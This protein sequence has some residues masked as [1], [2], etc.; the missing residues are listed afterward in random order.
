MHPADE[1]EPDISVVVVNHNTAH[2]LDRMFAALQVARGTLQIEVLIVDN[3]S[4][5]DSVTLIRRKYPTAILIENSINV[6]FGRANNQ[7]V[8]LARGRYILLLNTD[9]FVSPDTLSKS[10]TFM[11]SHPDCGVLGVKLVS[12]DGT[13][14]PSCRNFP[15]PWNTFL[16]ATGFD[17]VFLRFASKDHRSEEHSAARAC[18]W[19]PGCYYLTRRSVVDQIGLFDPRYF[20]YFEEVDHCRR[21]HQAGWKVIY[22]PDTQVIHLGGE[23]AKSRGPIT[24]VSRQALELQVESELLYLRKHH[25]M[26]GVLAGILLETVSDLF[27][28]VKGVLGSR[29]RA[30]TGAALQHLN[31]LYKALIA[32]RLASHSTR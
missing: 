9:A 27:N 12:E 1:T 10:V 16:L 29:N 18:D 2:L 31:L 30:R 4:R 32:T 15:T 8:Q 28:A 7:A 13:L 23:S 22:Y 19:V 25:G 11:D 20:L 21:V 17:Q 3:A 5:D 14:Q 6:G 24:V 26:S